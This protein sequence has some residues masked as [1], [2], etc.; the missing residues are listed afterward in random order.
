MIKNS[1]PN[2]PFAKMRNDRESENEIIALSVIAM[3]SHV[4]IS[5]FIHSPLPIESSSVES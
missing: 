2:T 5:L 3:C 4:G 1:V